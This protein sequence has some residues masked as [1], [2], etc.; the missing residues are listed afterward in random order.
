MR[1][2]TLRPRPCPA[3]RTRKA[4]AACGRGAVWSAQSS[5]RA[6]SAEAVGVARIEGLEPTRAILARKARSLD[7]GEELRFASAMY[8]PIPLVD[9]YSIRK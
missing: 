8:H 9:P 7:L 4:A 5:L 1:G 6:G 3:G 2:R